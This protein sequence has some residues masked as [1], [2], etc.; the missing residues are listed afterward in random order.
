ML[1]NGAKTRR[2]GSG[3]NGRCPLINQLIK[4]DVEPRFKL[5]TST[6][7]EQR[8][9]SN[10]ISARLHVLFHRPRNQDSVTTNDNTTS[11]SPFFSAGKRG[12][13]QHNTKQSKGEN[14]EN[15]ASGPTHVQRAACQCRASLCLIGRSPLESLRSPSQDMPHVG[16]PN[17][18]GCPGFFFFLLFFPPPLWACLRLNP[19]LFLDFFD[20][21]L[22]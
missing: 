18:P 21:F 6:S 1:G 2:T 17:S 15:T 11:S 9:L 3:S 19:D 22:A 20:F 8:E 10:L 14:Q 7:T 5:C 13:I 4:D 12:Q 16:C